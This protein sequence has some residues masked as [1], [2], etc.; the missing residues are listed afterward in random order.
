VRLV[1]RTRESEHELD[2]Q[3][4]TV[5]RDTALVRRALEG[6]EGRA[7]VCEL[8]THPIGGELRLDVDGE[9]SR[10]EAGR[11]G[12]ALLDLALTWGEQ[13]KAKGWTL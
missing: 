9:M 10:T 3:S 8:F 5:G 12:K 13:F 4:A 7:A 11:D 6:D 1:P 2:D